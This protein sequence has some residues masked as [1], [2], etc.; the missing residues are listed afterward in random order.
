MRKLFYIFAT[1]LLLF[2]CGKDVITVAPKPKTN[3]S[4]VYIAGD[5]TSA[6]K[7]STRQTALE[8]TEGYDPEE[9]PNVIPTDPNYYA[10]GWGEKLADLLDG[11]VVKN[12]AVGGMSTKTFM[13]KNFWRKKIMLNLIKNDIVL[14]Q[15]GHND[16]NQ[17][18]S[19]ERG[20]TPDQF[21]DNLVEMVTQVRGKSGIPVLLT[22]ICRYT[23]ED[24]HPKHSHTNALGDYKA[25]V[26]LA[27]TNTKC[28]YFDIE[29]AMWDLMD[30]LGEEE[31]KKFFMVSVEGSSDTTHLTEAGALQVATL[32][33]EALRGAR[34]EKISV[35]PK[36]LA[37]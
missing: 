17:T 9:N 31:S 35:L 37:P 20:T 10:W 18:A 22:P 32:V 24:G 4:K 34:N 16:E 11:N 12:E 2:G 36:P 25:K 27:A 19:D 3:K 6:S 15:F 29:Q 8:A 5:S 21:Y 33:V 7:K 26:I 28:D 23:W 30:Q 14:I 13:S 1:A